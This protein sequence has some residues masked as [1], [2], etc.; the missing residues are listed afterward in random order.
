[1]TYR[2][3]NLAG[4]KKLAAMVYKK[5]G[6]SCRVFGLIGTLGAGKTAFT[7]ALA[8]SMGIKDAKSPTFVLIHCYV[9]GKKSL[10]HID[11]YRLEKHAELEPLGLDEIINETNSIVVIEWVDKF[12]QLMKKCDLLIKFEITKDNNRNVTITNT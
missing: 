5:S 12:P 4:V 10:Y 9:Q 3:L 2:N 7:K 8:H 1:M 6:P 11:L